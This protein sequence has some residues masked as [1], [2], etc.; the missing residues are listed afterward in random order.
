[1]HTELVIRASLFFN[2]SCV[3]VLGSSGAGRGF[4]KTGMG[5]IR[6]LQ[7]GDRYPVVPHR[8]FLLPYAPLL[9]LV[10]QVHERSHGE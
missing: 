10:I 2:T 4:S 5:A 3:P 9:L 1:M 8:S 6:V 7:L